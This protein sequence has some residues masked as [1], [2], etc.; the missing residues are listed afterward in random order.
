MRIEE[1]WN[2]SIIALQI[3]FPILEFEINGNGLVNSYSSIRDI[4]GQW[5]HYLVE[6]I[7]KQELPTYWIDDTLNL[8]TIVFNENLRFKE[9]IYIGP[10][11]EVKYNE[12]IGNA[13]LEHLQLTEITQN[14]LKKL[15]LKMKPS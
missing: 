6:P 3:K 9:P 2:K 1:Y 8:F 7:D 11:K 14:Q 12:L 13:E 5:N 4:I 15:K 10:L